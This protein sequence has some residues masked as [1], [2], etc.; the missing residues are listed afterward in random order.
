M[1]FKMINKRYILH[2][3]FFLVLLCGISVF[4]LQANVD[5]TNDATETDEKLINIGE[6]RLNFKVI[7]GGDL[8]ILFESGGG[9]DSS[10]WHSLVKTVAHETGATIVTYDR[11]GFGKSDLPEI[12]YDMHLE[13][14]WLF[15]GL[16]KL[17]IEKNLILVGHSY[18]GW[19]IRLTASMF[20][21]KVSGMVFVDPFSHEFVDILGIEYL[22]DHPI[23]GK[24]PFDTSKPEKLTKIQRAMVR[25]VSDGLRRK[26]EIMRSTTIPEGIPVRLITSGISFLPKQEEQTAWREAHEQLAA[27]IKGAKLIVAE[28][29][30]HMI[31]FQQPKIIINA[32]S[33][34]ILLAKKESK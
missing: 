16:K 1:F 24:L 29:S 27:K 26:T 22:K 33:E 20:P 31:P 30:S 2:K 23:A 25:M 18:G 19:L 13:T 32:I 4:L 5:Q 14:K 11:A 28:H 12:P 7:K 17:G 9:M 21:S 34:V 8:T 10:E 15:I 3:I 6:C